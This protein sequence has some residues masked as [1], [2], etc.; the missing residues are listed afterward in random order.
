MPRDGQR[1]RAV[2][3]L[4]ARSLGSSHRKAVRLGVL[5]LPLAR[6]QLGRTV[7]SAAVPYGYTLSIW[8]GGSV[9]IHAFGPPRVIDA[10]LFVAGGAMGFLATEILASGDIRPRLRALEPQPPMAGWGAVQLLPAGMS[11]LAAA[12]ATQL[13]GDTLAW[14]AAGFLVTIAYLILSALQATLASRERLGAEDRPMCRR[15]GGLQ[16]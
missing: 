14:P 3:E 7:D 1:R 16:S 11:V 10:L 2:V 6:H 15:C 9:A 8:G 12:A 13:L 5:L 4:H